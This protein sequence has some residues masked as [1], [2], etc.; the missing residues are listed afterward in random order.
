M[1]CQ[2][3]TRNSTL[4]L[5]ADLPLTRQTQHTTV[6]VLR[7]TTVCVFTKEYIVTEYHMYKQQAIYT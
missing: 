7:H 5:N 2:K 3:H 6:I 4:Y 1:A